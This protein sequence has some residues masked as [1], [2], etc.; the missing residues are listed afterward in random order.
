MKKVALITGGTKGLGKAIVLKLLDEGVKVAFTYFSDDEAANKIVDLYSEDAIC[1]KSDSSKSDEAYRV[2]E[3][4]IKHFGK[5]DI[6]VNNVFGAKDGSVINHSF[7]MME[8]TMNHTFYPAYHHIVAVAKHMKDNNYGRIVNIG[9]VNGMRGREGSLA[10][11]S[12]KSA[13]TGLSKTVAKELG[14]YN[15][16][17]NIV[18]PGYIDTD[19]QKNTSE[20]IKKMV[21]EESVVKKLPKPEEIANIVYFLTVLDS[22]NITG[23]T[24]KIDCGQY[25]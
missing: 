6:L 21:L 19:G 4:T 20:L 8:Y 22:G 9:S 24:I 13:L 16:T 23:E 12:A 25:I 7:E 2:V 11:S 5:I 1:F 18:A 15:V 17:C 10:Y 14:R 3:E